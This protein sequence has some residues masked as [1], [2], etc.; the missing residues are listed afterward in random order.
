M[1]NQL[2]LDIKKTSNEFGLDNVVLSTSNSKSD[3]K[4]AN[5]ISDKGF[6]VYRGEED[7][8]IERFT[9]AALDCKFSHVV[10]ITGDDLFRDLNS[11]KIMFNEMVQKI[12]IMYFLM[13]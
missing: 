10:R 3:N 6:K 4:L 1:E 13:I 12:W 2:F 9:S 8:L 5:Y 7:N 11:I